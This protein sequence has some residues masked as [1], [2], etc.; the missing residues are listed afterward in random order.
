MQTLET[1]DR[2]IRTSQDLLS[3]V[4]T[5]KSLAA[6]NIRHYEQAVASLLAYREVVDSGWQILL[7]NVSG[8]RWETRGTRGVCLV[9]GTDQGLCGQFNEILLDHALDRCREL[10]AGGLELTFWSLGL[11]VR[12]ALLDRRRP[13]A[14]HFNEPTG[15][16]TANRTVQ[17]LVAAM[18]TARQEPGVEYFFVA[19]NRLAGKGSYTQRFERLLPFDRAWA[20]AYR[21]RK[22]PNRCLP[23]VGLAAREMFRYLFRQHL[24][25]ALYGAVAHSLAAENAARLMAMQAAEKNILELE[26]TLR[27]QFR[28]MRQAGITNELLDIVAGFEALKEGMAAL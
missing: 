26:E 11:K 19:H 9:V 23:Q 27:A 24:F 3:V 6:V 7:R 4:K 2:K 25:V 13:G 15:L 10:A 5:M 18:E 16:A 20:E 28:E 8:W 21:G 22:W 17:R 14:Q 12:D 1:L